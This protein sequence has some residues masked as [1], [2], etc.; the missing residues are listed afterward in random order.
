M[1]PTETLQHYESLPNEAKLQVIDF[2]EFMRSRYQAKQSPSPINSIES[3]FGLITAKHSVT[4][5]E[6]DQAIKAEGGKL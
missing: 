5:E 4:L 3:S 6:M 1:L 2:I